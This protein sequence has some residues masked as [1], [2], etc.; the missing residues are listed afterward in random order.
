MKQMPTD[1]EV[2][3]RFGYDRPAADRPILDG[4]VTDAQLLAAGRAFRRRR[5]IM[6]WAVRAALIVLLASAWQFI[7]DR[8]ID[9]FW[10]SS[11][12]AVGDRLILW[13][14]DG[15]LLRNLIATVKVMLTGFIVGVAMAVTLGFVLGRVKFLAQLLTPFI[16]GVYSMPK[17]ALAPLFIM[18]FGIGSTS[19]VLLTVMIVFFMVFYNTFSGVRDVDRELLDVAAVMGAS[20]SALLRKVV[21]PSAAEWIFTGLRLAVPYSLVG[22]VVAEILAGNEGIGY[23]VRNSSGTFDTTG[24]FAALGALIVVGMGLN[25]FV[26][27]SSKYT[28]RWRQAGY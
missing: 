27:W 21:L 8:F 23:L 22:A 13:I 9:A 6:L 4:E 12:S 11:P 7:S 26:E 1:G 17:L 15:T 28:G 3:P 5:T 19:K 2:L 18:W 10:I 25:A 14:T 20:R 24:T 16:Q